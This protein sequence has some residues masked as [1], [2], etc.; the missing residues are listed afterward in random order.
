MRDGADENS[1][2]I[3][4]GTEVRKRFNQ[5]LIERAAQTGGGPA[6]SPGL[7]SFDS[8]DSYLRFWRAIFERG[9][10][11]GPV[12]AGAV[13]ALALIGRAT[14]SELL[15]GVFFD[16]RPVA[17][18]SALLMLL[19]AA[20]AL[21]LRIPSGGRLRRRLGDLLAALAAGLATVAFAVQAS[22]SDLLPGEL[23]RA[24]AS[25]SL[26]LAILLGIG[27]IAVD[28][29]GPG[30]RFSDRLVPLIGMVALV[31]LLSRGYRLDLI[32]GT[33]S[34]EVSPFGLLGLGALVVSYLGLRP[35]RGL[36]G[37][38]VSSGP[39]PA[40]ARLLAPAVLAIPL[41]MTVGQGASGA[42]EATSAD[43][44]RWVDEMIVMV[45]LVAV[46]TY[47]SKRL[48]SYFED[49]R[50]AAEEL[51]EQADVLAA[52]A[53]GVALLRLSDDRLILT[54]PQFDRMHGYEPGGLS[55]KP[56]A[57]ITPDDLDQEEIRTREQ[58][59]EELLEEGRAAF[60]SRALRRD[61]TVIR[62]RTNSIL[63]T[64]PQHGAVLI[65][66]KSDITAEYEAKLAGAAAEARFRQVF[67]QSPIG[68]ALVRPDGSFDRV[69]R[70]FEDLT[71]YRF[72]RLSE[73]TFSEITHPEDL[74]E[75][76]RR[77]EEMFRGETDGF[78]MEKRYIRQDGGV[79]RVE[80]R[81]VML[82]DSSGDPTV[83]LSM[84]RDVTAHHEMSLR[85]RRLADHDPLTG[86]FNRRRLEREL[87]LT[88]AGSD[89]SPGR[90][91]AVMMVDLDNFKFI[92]DNYGHTVGDRL[93]VR[94][95]E[96][97]KARLRHGDVLARQGGDE[98]VL[99]LRDVSAREALPIA[100]ELVRE[101]AAGA[102]VEGPGF[103]ARATA[104]IGVAISPDGAA[105]DPERLIREADIAMYEVKDSGRN[106]AGLYDSSR[107]SA[108]TRGID[109]H[110]RI[111]R[112]LDRDEFTLYSQPVISLRDDPLPHFELFLRL[113]HPGGRPVA[114]S[115]FMP[116]AERYN[117]VGEIDRWVVR[118]AVRMLARCEEGRA[119]RLF[120]NLSGQSVGD[121]DLL[122]LIEEELARGAVDPDL[123]V[124]EVTETSAIAD[125]DRAQRF[126][127]AL[128]LIGCHT[129]LDDFG[130][131]FASF[132]YLKHV[133]SDYVKI[134]GE[135]IRNLPDDPTSQLLV[136]ALTDLSRGLGK[137]VVA[138]HVEDE[139]ALELLQGYGVD[140]V[141]G[142]LLGRPRPAR[143]EDMLLPARGM[144]PARK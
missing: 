64:D 28:R 73:M 107:P 135:F 5:R 18:L 122:A 131:G 141:Q 99:M 101:I 6:S 134:D 27:M 22:G 10:V 96:V 78:E 12:L 143:P 113:P 119:P 49:W 66:V 23:L 79:V 57:A 126:T 25:S 97:L 70:G 124:F 139:R 133:P 36:A 43:L 2:V 103:L 100:R 52:M 74:A 26:L 39:G 136:R 114:P 44:I 106:D 9:A 84:V 137:Q 54:N 142:Y 34:A 40:M 80:L 98:F 55:G 63:T 76:L 111:R 59:A 85:L 69:N 92:N 130:A 67:E 35:D 83:A 93:I 16:S 125:I 86:L 32:S 68:L 87:E 51:R 118:R 123:L 8:P 61:G 94:T 17:M 1:D 3:E 60:E 46:I 30:H 75:D 108:M 37:F 65:I 110:E 42:G 41:A 88:V 90:G 72:E 89:G 95:S 138:E 56:V 115:A 19:L 82:R 58:V 33:L 71:G 102:R 109:W 105:V 140:L 50:R 62:C 45:A 15:A 127:A 81:A 117:M 104:S 91:L 24:P 14:G 144:R 77:T 48:Q 7:R 116:V 129:A 31:G 53:E 47:T 132:Y 38:M 11:A 20:A 120:V 121:M 21:N 112:A 4:P 29:D 128:S 13:G